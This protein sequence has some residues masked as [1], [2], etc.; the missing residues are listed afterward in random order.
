M[1]SVA[2]LLRQV[3][4]GN[5]IINELNS[6][7]S[8]FTGCG[9]LTIVLKLYAV[10]GVCTSPSMSACSQTLTHTKSATLGRFF[11]RTAVCCLL[12]ANYAWYMIMTLFE[13][14]YDVV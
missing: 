2:R 13:Y 10:C 14:D 5:L 3:S 1:Y 11:S 4:T 7:S 8:D 9:S 6:S 12:I